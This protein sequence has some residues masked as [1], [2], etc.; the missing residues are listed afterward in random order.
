M[1]NAALRAALL[2][3]PFLPILAGASSLFA[4]DSPPAYLQIFREEVKPGRSGPHVAAEAGWPRAFARAKIPNFYIAMTTT[5]GPAEAWFVEGHASV[6]EIAA[7][8]KTIDAAPGLNGELDRLAQADAANISSTRVVLGR[9]LPDLSNGVAIDV[10][11]MHVWEVLIFKVR[12]GHELD[13]AE[14]AKLYKSTV[15]QAKID[16]PWATYAVLAGMPGPVFLVFIPHRTL[17]EIDP[18][19]GVGAAIE[20]AFTEE[21]MKRL[22]TLAQGYESVEDMVF[23]VSPQMSHL[24]DEFVARDP[25]FWTRK[26]AVAKGR[27]AAAPPA[28]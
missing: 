14:A 28:Q 23:T 15:E 18:A 25:K 16:A 12:P 3:A 19:T 22:G 24:S 5:Y 10:A 20:K 13:F 21:A 6:A 17:E 7:V 1:P 26:P 4:Q 11:R 2:L 9:Y 8:N 27:P